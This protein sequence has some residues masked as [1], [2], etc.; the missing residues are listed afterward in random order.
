MSNTD[1]VALHLNG[2]PLSVPAGTSVAAALRIADDAHLRYLSIQQH[3]ARSS[4]AV[5]ILRTKR[6][7]V[8]SKCRL[9]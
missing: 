5:A 3:G 1:T 7:Q 2:R 9:T 8:N 4:G 6:E